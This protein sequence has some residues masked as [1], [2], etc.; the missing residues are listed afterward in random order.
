MT[1]VDTEA[2]A[3]LLQLFADVEPNGTADA[4]MAVRWCV[5][6]GLTQLIEQHE[7]AKPYLMIVVRPFTQAGGGI[8]DGGERAYSRETHRYFVPLTQELQYVAFSRPGLNSVFATVVWNSDGKGALHLRR[9]FPPGSGS[10]NTLTFDGAGELRRL[11]HFDRTS[12][13]VD[14]TGQLLHEV[15]DELTVSVPEEMFAKEP[16]QWA[17]DYIGKF[18]DDQ[19]FDQCHFRRRFLLGL[20]FMPIYFVAAYMVRFAFLAL[21]L[22]FGMPGMQLRGFVHPLQWGIKDVVDSTGDPVWWFHK[23]GRTRNPLVW[24]FNPVTILLVTL[25]ILGVSSFHVTRNEQVV[26]WLGW[27]WWECLGLSVLIH[28]GVVAVGLVGFLL[29]GLISLLPFER[30]NKRLNES[31]KRRSRTKQERSAA[32]LKEAQEAT[33]RALEQMICSAASSSVSVSALPQEKRTIRLR[34]QATKQKV[35]KPFAR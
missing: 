23:D 21:C 33:K 22:L 16:P 19:A 27:S 25:V 2:P 24:P 31:S 11:R 15:S 28:L 10:Y 9:A 20:A 3:S 7:V 1:A 29:I 34:F 17:K 6:P 8:D 13:R 32:E 14:Y 18:A 30:L 26:H 35:C 12:N 5:T 4:V